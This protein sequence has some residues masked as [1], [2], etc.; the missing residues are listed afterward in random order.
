[1]YTIHFHLLNIAK[2]IIKDE[3]HMY[4]HSFHVLWSKGWTSTDDD[5]D[6]DDD[7]KDDDDDNNNIFCSR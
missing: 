6:D 3:I 5:D 7:D 2:I 4:Q 1:L